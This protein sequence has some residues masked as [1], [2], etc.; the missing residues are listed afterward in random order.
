MNICFIVKVEMDLIEYSDLYKE[1]WNKFIQTSKNGT[2]LFNRNYIEYH[3]NRFN[4]R[5]L[6]FRKKNDIR[7]VI[8]FNIN[9]SIAYSHQGLTYGGFIFAKDISIQEVLEAFNLLNNYLINIGVVEMVYK[10]VPFIYHSYPA[11]EDLYALFRLDAQII[12]RNISTTINQNCKLKF[13]ESRLS[14]LRKGKRNSFIVSDDLKFNDFWKILENNLLNKYET[15]PVHTCDEIEYLQKQFP[16]NIKLHTVINEGKVMSGCVIFKDQQ[17]AHVQYISSTSEGR[18]MG[19]LDILFDYLINHKYTA[20]P[21]FDLGSSN[22]EMGR[23]L[24]AGLIFQ[25]EGFGGRG[26]CYDIYKYDTSKIIA[27]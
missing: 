4:N 6:I 15:K 17:V 9:D 5:A 8:A 3:F 16:E 21:F 2:F 18:Q 1:G 26:V 10:P 11:Q 19:A 27:L 12:G 13:T 25:K 23:Y 7:A 20:S 22:E 14:G 24:N